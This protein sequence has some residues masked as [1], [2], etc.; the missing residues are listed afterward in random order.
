MHELL[1][2]NAFKV[3]FRANLCS[4]F[5]SRCAFSLVK[6]FLATLKF[7][8]HGDTHFATAATIG[9]WHRSDIRSI[10]CNLLVVV[11]Y[12]AE[13]CPGRRLVGWVVFVFFLDHVDT[14]F[15]LYSVLALSI[16]SAALGQTADCPYRTYAGGEVYPMEWP[17]SVEHS[18]HYSKA[19]SM[20]RHFLSFFFSQ[21]DSVKDV[22]HILSMCLSLASFQTGSIL[23]GDSCWPQR[24]VQ[25]H[26]P[27]RLQRSVHGLI[28][29]QLAHKGVCWNIY[30]DSSQSEKDCLKIW[31]LFIEHSDLFNLVARGKEILL[32]WF[33][34]MYVH[35]KT[36]KCYYLLFLIF[37]EIRG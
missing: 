12:L 8:S 13:H 25:G 22:N 36:T 23:G 19:Q 35:C 4:F 10:S 3:K 21:M 34:L 1:D 6:I 16:A 24:K 18:L 33:F 20:S 2:K 30:F 11:V 31:I 29:V 27:H 26:E 15:A 32:L 9:T 17:R 7:H 28:V 14:M 37:R 5:L